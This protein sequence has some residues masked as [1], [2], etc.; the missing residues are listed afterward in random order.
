MTEGA[1]PETLAELLR[2]LERSND[3]RTLARDCGL[4]VRELRRRLAI[5]RRELQADDDDDPGAVPV[6]AVAVP[7]AQDPA[8]TWPELPP[9]AVLVTNPLP[10]PGGVLEIHTDGASRGNPGPAAVGIVFG[11]KDGPALCVHG[12][13]IG[14]ATNNVAE[15]RAAVI[16]LE[17]CRRWGVRRVHLV[18]DSE[19]IVRQLHGAYRVKSPDL[20]PLYQQVVFLSRGL[21]EFRV[22]HVKRE[23][24]AHADAVANRALDA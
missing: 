12:E 6:A 9:A 7:A 2:T 19:L 24:N 23:L 15:Y 5:W 4:S 11:V 16:A 10:E 20:R 18:M 3:L 22:R 1:H 8:G 13:A 17:H 21:Q 14:R